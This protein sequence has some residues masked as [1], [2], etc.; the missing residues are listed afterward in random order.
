MLWPVTTCETPRTDSVPHH[1]RGIFHVCRE[2][3]DASRHSFVGI[4]QPNCDEIWYVVFGRDASAL[5]D[6]MWVWTQSVHVDGVRNRL[7]SESSEDTDGDEHDRLQE[8][9]GKTEADVA[10]QR[11]V[12]GGSV[13]TGR[14]SGHDSLGRSSNLEGISG[15]TQSSGAQEASDCESFA[16]AFAEEMN[17]LA[18]QLKH[19]SRRREEP[20]N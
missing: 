17:A 8:G 13:G 6:S 9:N 7:R 1:T 19:S 5:M 18:E 11:L 2:A 15:C 10:Q 12:Y 14:R 4:L 16:Q 3:G 20:E